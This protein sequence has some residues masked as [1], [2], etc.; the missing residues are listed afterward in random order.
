MKRPIVYGIALACAIA[1]GGGAY[2]TFFST[3]P[4]PE[5]SFATTQGEQFT[6]RDLRGKVVLVNFWA[7][8]CETCVHEMPALVD[9]YNKFKARGFETVAVAMSYDPPNYVLNY[10]NKT[11]LPFKIAFDPT[12]RIA[13]EFGNVRLT[14]T[15]FILDR[16]GNVIKRYLGGPNFAELHAL[17]DAELN[18]KGV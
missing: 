14:P 18:K 4:A 5:V 11:A 7:T 16:R 2:S 3:Q 6:T 1:I 9:T 15:T 8:S 13:Q 12:G 10:V 17:L